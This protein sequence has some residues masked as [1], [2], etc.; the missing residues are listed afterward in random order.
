M[1][2]SEMDEKEIIDMKDGK[3]HGFLRDAEM[4]FDE[5]TRSEEHTSELQSP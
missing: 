3:K 5:E 4:L 1:R 2:L